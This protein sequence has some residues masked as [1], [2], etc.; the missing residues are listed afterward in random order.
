ML[1][2]RDA[3]KDADQRPVGSLFILWLYVCQTRLLNWKEPV[4]NELKTIII[5]SVTKGIKGLITDEWSLHANHV[6]E[7][8]VSPM[9][10]PCTEPSQTSHGTMAYLTHTCHG[11]LIDLSSCTSHG[12]IA[13]LSWN[14]HI[15]VV[16]LLQTSEGPVAEP[17]WIFG[18]PLMKPLCTSCRTITDLSCT[19]HG[20]LVEPSIGGSRGRARRTPLRVQILLFWHTKFAKRNASG[21]HAPPLFDIRHFKRKI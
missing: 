7:P 21:V 1:E 14:H 12:T 2:D 4:R 10:T 5:I 15:P 8:N 19:S 6:N 11:L 16:H 17:F 20:P 3:K 18:G 9:R 13:D